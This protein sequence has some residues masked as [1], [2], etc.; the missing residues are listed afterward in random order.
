ME[1]YCLSPEPGLPS[2][3]NLLWILLHAESEEL[4]QEI[5]T[6]MHQGWRSFDEVGSGRLQGQ[7]F[8]GPG[9]PRDRNGKTI[10]PIFKEL[11]EILARMQCEQ[12]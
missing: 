11:C 7:D 5:S 1:G 4:S 8:L 10:Q 9:M 2:L 6:L 3:H 12:G